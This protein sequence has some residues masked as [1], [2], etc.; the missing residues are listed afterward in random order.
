MYVV[1][2]GTE[3]GVYWRVTY[4]LRLG[5][6]E[7]GPWERGT[8]DSVSPFL[9][10]VRAHRSSNSQHGEPRRCWSVGWALVRV[11]TYP[12]GVPCPREHDF[13]YQGKHTMMSEETKQE[14][15]QFRFSPFSG[16]FLPLIRGSAFSFCVLHFHLPIM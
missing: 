14:R 13:E 12:A 9:A 5:V 1:C 2:S 6:G 8:P 7:M 4:L 11:C 10:R 3:V 16:I 15:Q